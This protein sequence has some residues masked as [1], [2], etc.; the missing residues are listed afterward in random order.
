M[1]RLKKHGINCLQPKRIM[2]SGKTRVQCFD[3]TGTLTKD[4]LDFIGFQPVRGVG[5]GKA[6]FFVGDAA[7]ATPP[8]AC[9]VVCRHVA[10]GGGGAQCGFQLTPPFFSRSGHPRRHGRHRP[11]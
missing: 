2:I 8:T 4:G 10:G 1:E 3:K 5:E 6:H 11:P 9:G 7:A